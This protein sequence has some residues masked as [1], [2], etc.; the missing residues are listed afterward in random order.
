MCLLQ[1]I[2][3]NT[4]HLQPKVATRPIKVIKIGYFSY[5]NNCFVSKIYP[6]E[7]K[8]GE[9]Y[10]FILPKPY[11]GKVMDALSYLNCENV[12]IEIGFHSYRDLPTME[13]CK[14]GMWGW[15]TTNQN[16]NVLAN[17]IA[18]FE[19]PTGA[20]YYSDGENHYVSDSIIFRKA[21]FS[22]KE[23]EAENFKPEKVL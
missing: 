18:I 1:T 16:N 4:F 10:S 8:R 5:T 13:K 19:I 2:Q 12:H 9:K 15:L 20:I 14:M 3:K 6:K 22:P 17:I 11:I 23:W 7:Y 21:I